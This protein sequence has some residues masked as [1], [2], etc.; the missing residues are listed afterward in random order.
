MPLIRHESSRRG[1]LALLAILVFLLSGC[2]RVSETS[3]PSDSMAPSEPAASVSEP[4]EPETPPSPMADGKL[5]FINDYNGNTSTVFHSDTVVYS[6]KGLAYQLTGGGDDYFYVQSNVGDQYVFSLCDASGTVRIEDFGGYPAGVFGNWLIVTGYNISDEEGRE[7]VYDLRTMQPADMGPS[8]VSSA[9]QIGDRLVINTADGM[10]VYAVDTLEQL[11]FYPGWYGDPLSSWTSQTLSE[12]VQDF[13]MM[14]LYDPDTGNSQYRL[15]NPLTGVS[16][17]NVSSYLDGD[18][19]SV[20]VGD[21]Y[22]IYDLTTGEKV[23]SDWRSYNYYSDAVKIYRAG[24]SIL[25]SAPAYGGTKEVQY[26]YQSSDAPY[27]YVQLGDGT[28]DVLDLSGNLVLQ[29]SPGE[30]QMVT[31]IGGGRLSIYNY[32]GGGGTV[33]CWP[34]GRER[35]FDEYTNIVGFYGTDGLLLGSYQIGNSYL[36]DL[37]DKDGDVL[38]KGL[39][40]YSYAGSDQFIYAEISF[41][42]GYITLDGQWLW[43]MSTFQSTD[44]EPDYYW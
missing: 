5:R 14:N 33:V 21:T 41:R 34:D 28:Y 32:S 43:S 12:T 35:E 9:N 16:Y 25:V 3:A 2:T 10:G 17:D 20:E 26:A 18:Y 27:T 39:K 44:A 15:Y 29:L 8:A 40:N 31:D 42:K 4:E 6:G 11:E 13:L 23:D 38:L 19:F 24:T 30:D 37:L 7:T 22:E 36:Y 1:A